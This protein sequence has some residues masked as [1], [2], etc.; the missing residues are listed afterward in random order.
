[1]R[2]IRFMVWDT[3]KKEWARIDLDRRETLPAPYVVD[4]LILQ[5]GSDERYLWVAFS[6]LKDK[7]GRPIYEGDIC[8]SDLQGTGELVE[9]C[10]V[11]G[12][13]VGRSWGG[14]SSLLLYNWLPNMIEVIGTIFE[15][16]ELIK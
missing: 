13:F 5:F 4:N 8:R 7:H 15:N 14:E 6:G 12:A 9:V 10:F 1:M 3:L 16:P 11:D 2:E